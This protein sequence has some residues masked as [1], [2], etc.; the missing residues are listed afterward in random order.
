MRR[1]EILHRCKRAVKHLQPALFHLGETVL[2]GK[3]VDAPDFPQTGFFNSI[4][5]DA[6]DKCLCITLIAF[7][8]AQHGGI[9]VSFMTFATNGSYAQKRELEPR[10]MASSNN[11]NAPLNR[12]IYNSIG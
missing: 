2:P 8:W 4:E 5:I 12:R 3:I 6:H 1:D 10:Q 7:S 9:Y 11:V